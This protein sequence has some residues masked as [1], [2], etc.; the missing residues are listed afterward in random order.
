MTGH[1]T[2]SSVGLGVLGLSTSEIAMKVDGS[3]MSKQA[4]AIDFHA[5]A[6]EKD[7]SSAVKPLLVIGFAVIIL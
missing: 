3:R 7:V 4:V 6:L 5:Q 1:S 2:L